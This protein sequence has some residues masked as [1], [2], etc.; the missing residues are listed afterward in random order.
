MNPL[1]VVAE[2]RLTPSRLKALWKRTEEVTKQLRRKKSL[3]VY[4]NCDRGD[5]AYKAHLGGGMY[6]SI[7]EDYGGLEIRRYEAAEGWPPLVPTGERIYIP[8]FQ[9]DA[10]KR[11]LCRLYYAYPELREVEECA[12]E[13]SMDVLDCKECLPFGLLA[14]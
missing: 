10:F 4:K 3:K 1:T 13:F 5:S 2:V 9:W 8:A 12:H 7:G 11:N 6:I 14:L